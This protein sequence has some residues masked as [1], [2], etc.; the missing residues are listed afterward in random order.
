MLE[1]NRESSF[2]KSK[3]FVLL[4]DERLNFRKSV[5]IVNIMV[6]RLL[7]LENYEKS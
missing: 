7:V 1:N 4:K 2:L 3:A 6:N 5:N